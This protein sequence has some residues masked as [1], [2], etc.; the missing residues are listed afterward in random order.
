[1]N[2]DDYEKAIAIISEA[3]NEDLSKS[4]DWA[5]PGCDESVPGNFEICWKC[6]SESQ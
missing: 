1:M 6:G 4:P 2:D 5:C 3:L